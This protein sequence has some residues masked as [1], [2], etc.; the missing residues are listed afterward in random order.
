YAGDTKGDIYVTFTGGGSGGGNA[1]KK[2]S[3]GLDGSAIQAIVTDP[4]RGSKAAYAVTASGVYF[5]ADSSASSPS[6]V[7]IT[8]NLFGITRR[9]FN[10]PNEVGPA[11]S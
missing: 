6:W 3:T 8:G 10:D 11:L 5:M 7:S 4:R 2:I 1:W 9:W